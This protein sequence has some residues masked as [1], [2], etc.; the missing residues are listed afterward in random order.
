MSKYKLYR[1]ME[2][3][4]WKY[5][6]AFNSTLDPRYHEIINRLNELDIEWELRDFEGVVKFKSKMK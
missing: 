1:K 2:S 3:G 6:E 5:S 4:K